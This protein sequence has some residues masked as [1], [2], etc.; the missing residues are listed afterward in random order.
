[1]RRL[2]NQGNTNS[3]PARASRRR[4][5]PMRTH[6]AGKRAITEASE[7]PGASSDIASGWRRTS[8]RSDGGRLGAGLEDFFERP[9]ADL[10]RF[11]ERLPGACHLVHDALERTLELV[12]GEIL[13]GRVPHGRGDVELSAEEVH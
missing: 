6:H 5:A 10:L 12:C 7:G 9:L 4:I 1:M 2:S 8:R 13:D 3:S 11:G